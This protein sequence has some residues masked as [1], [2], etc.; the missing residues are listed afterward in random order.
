MKERNGK[1]E[2]HFLYER[3][4]WKKRN[5]FN[6]KVKANSI[7]RMYSSNLEQKLIQ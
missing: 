3:K 5:S 7:T 4:E 2:S 1:K 6:Q